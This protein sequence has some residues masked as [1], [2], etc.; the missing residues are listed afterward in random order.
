MIVSVNWL[1]KYLKGDYSIDELTERI[2]SRL[3]EIESVQD[4]KDKY[5]DATVVKVVECVEHPNSDHLHICQ[6]DDGGVTK[7]IPRSESGSIQVV[8][9]APNVHA[10]MLAAW[11]PVGAIVPES[12]GTADEFKLSARKLRGVISYG[13]LASPRE[14]ALWNEH[15]GII[16]LPADEMTVGEKL[17]E[18]LELDDYLLEVENKS[19]THR[20]D[21]FGLIGFAREVAAIFGESADIPAWFDNQVKTDSLT[22]S[23]RPTVTIADDHL[24]SR[25]EC[26]ALDNVDSSRQ[27]P[28]LWRSYVSRSGSNSISA[29]VDITNLLMYQ[30]GQPLHAFD[31]DKLIE[32]SPTGKPDIVVRAARAGEKLELLDGRQIDLDPADIV[33]AVGTTEKS[34]PVALA[35][36]MGGMASEITP[37]TKRVL[38]ESA[39]FDLYHL[40]STQFRHGIFSE[41][42]TRFTKGQPAELTQPV[43]L[44]AVVLMQR[45][46]GAT[47]ISPVIDAYPVQWQELSLDIP[48]AHFTD[49]LGEYNDGGYTG[50]LI[51]NTLSNLGYRHIIVRDGSVRANIPWWR[52]DQRIDEDIIEDIGRVNGFDNIVDKLPVR[53]LKAAPYN[54]LLQKENWLKDR[55]RLM[56]GNEVVTYSFVH[57]DLLN[58]VHDDPKR[59][60]RITNAISPRLQYYRRDLLPGLLPIARDNLRAG[61]NDFMLFEVGKVHRQ[62]LMDAGEPTLPAEIPEVSGLLVDKN[63]HYGAAFYQLKHILKFA[64]NIADD[65]AKLVRLDGYRGELDTAANIFEPQRSA[66]VLIEDQYAGIVGE[67]KADVLAKFKLPAYTAGFSLHIQAIAD[68]L[69]SAADYQPVSRYQGTSRDI[70]YQVAADVDYVK[71]YNFTLQY[72]DSK[73]ASETHRYRLSPVDIYLVDGK[74]KNITLHIDFSDMAGTVGTGSVNKIMDK[75]AV[76]ATKQLGVKVI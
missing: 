61:Y 44:H 39:T 50:A 49:V 72:L 17:S 25:Y 3:V 40:R 46:A 27:L 34:V 5:R 9:G 8:C 20:P 57:G 26:V 35:G 28:M 10:G 74:A 12:Y 51:A 30:T 42:V 21:C 38:L 54:A 24:C 60:Y 69:D 63:R 23:L 4:L 59:A 52:P 64:L 31:L 62:G 58:A 71:L 7:D 11:L 1:K 16:E 2:G 32:L 70:T 67:P 13:M 43:L 45:Y 33:V 14:L 48:V 36:A 75:L 56:G 37:A 19:L 18:A 22:G 65:Q 47:A 53:P 73:W 29:P 15:E 76:A 55:L 66:V 68:H 41:A 6:I